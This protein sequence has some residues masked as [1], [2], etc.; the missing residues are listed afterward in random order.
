MPIYATAEAKEFWQKCHSKSR[1]LA[2]SHFVSIADSKDDKQ[3]RKQ[4]CDAI[5]A[6]KSNP[7]KT[8]SYAGFAASL[9]GLGATLVFAK[10]EARLIVDS[11][12]GVLENGGLCLDRTSGIPFIPGSAIKGAARHFAISQLSET[13]T[14]DEKAKLLAKICRIFGYGSREWT[15]GRSGEQGEAVSDFWLAMVPLFDVGQDH[16]AARNE[17]WKSVS[18]KAVDIMITQ[19]GWKIALAVFASSPLFQR[20]IPELILTF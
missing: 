13:E 7:A 11:A 2:A 1:S 12:G 20:E 16:D 18:E 8:A 14:A 10:L 19:Q 6:G 9:Q 4:S 5:K 15:S 3:W 17:L